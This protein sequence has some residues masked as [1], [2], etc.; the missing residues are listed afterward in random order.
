MRLSLACL[1]L[2]V[3]VCRLPT[4]N[5]VG[6]DGERLRAVNWRVPILT[7]WSLVQL[8]LSRLNSVVM[9]SFDCLVSMDVL[10]SVAIAVVMTS[11]PYVP[12]IRLDLS[13]FRR[14]VW[15]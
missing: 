7:S 14:M 10:V 9:L 3:M 8:L 4:T 15:L 5:P 12:V 13:G 1:V 6:F 2:L 11:R